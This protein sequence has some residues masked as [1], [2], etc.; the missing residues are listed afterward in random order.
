MSKVR[1]KSKN[2]ED[3]YPLSPL[4]EGLLFH[5]LYAPEAGVY[6]T[7]VTCTLENLDVSALEQA[8]QRVV[9]RHPILRTAFIWKNLER[10]LQV[11]GRQVR[12]PLEGQDWRGL[13]ATGQE[14]RFAAYLQADRR[15]GFQLSQAPLMR[16]ALFQVDEDTYKLVWSHHHVL[17]DGWS[18]HLLIK[19]VFLLYEG[20]RK[21]QNI[22]LP[23]TRPYRDYIAWL[24]Q[25]DMAA[26]EAFWRQELAGFTAPNSLGIDRVMGGL[27]GEEKSPGEHRIKLSAATT[28]ALQSLARTSQLTLNTLVQGALALL[29]SRYSGEDDIVFG[30][31]VSGRPPELPGADATAG[32]FINTLPVR[33]R[34]SPN[35]PLL[36][37]LRQLQEQQV[38]M[39]RY[40]YSPLVNVQ[41]WSDVPRDLPLFKCLY[42]FEN[43]PVDAPVAEHEL[44][45]EVRDY[46][47]VEKVTYP[48]TI[49]SGPSQE[50]TLKALYDRQSFD[51][52]TVDRVL[53]HFRALLEGIVANPECRLFDLTPLTEAER[54]QLLVEWNET[55]ADYPQGR[56]IHGLF[57]AQVERSPEAI[58]AVCEGR[59]LTYEEL[60]KRANQLAH[61]LRALGVGPEVLVA[62][63]LD[64]TL[65]MLI[66]I[67]GI[68][69]ASGAY[70]PMDPAYPAERL[71][72]ILEDTQAP[73]LLTQARLKGMLPEQKAKVVCLDADWETI[74]GESSENLTGGVSDDNL[75]YVIYTS[76]STGRPK[77]VAIE[78][79]ST[80][81]LLNWAKEVFGP[82]NLAS[83]LASTSICFDLSVYEMFVPLS[84]GGEVILAENA[85][86]LPRLPEANH[87]TLINTVPS[88]IAELVRMRSVPQ[89]VRTVNLAGEPLPTRLV[90]QIYQQETVERVFD[91]YGPSEDTTYST[92]ALRRSEG[93][94]TI[95]RPI[96]NTQM[97]L[98]DGHLQ[99]TPLGVAG[100]L[101]I[102]GEGLARGYLNRPELTAEKFIPHPFSEKPGA[103]LYKTG[104]LARYL[105]DGN[106]EFLGRIDHQVKIRGFRIE[107]GEI[108]TV[109][110]RHPGVR[111]LVV[112]AREDAPG[113]KRLV[114]YIVPEPENKPTGGELR[115]YLQQKLPEYLVPSAFV[116]LEALPL[117]PNG[118]VDRKR[119][120]AP[121]QFS[122]ASAGTFVAPR[123]P[124]EELLAGIWVDVLSIPQVG[125][126]DDFFELGGHSLLATRLISRIRDAFQ[127][128]LPLASI[129]D[130]STI[131]SL[132]ERIEA[133]KRGGQS[134]SAPPLQPIPREEDLPL[135]FAQHRLWFL[136]QL[137]PGSNAYNIHAAVRLSGHLDAE[138]LEQSVSEVVRR[139]EALRTTFANVAGRPVQVI[140]PATALTL[141]RVD[142]MAL[143]ESDRESELLQLASAEAQRPFDLAAGPLF[144]ATLVQMGAEEHAVLLTMHHIISDGWSIG[145]LIKEM[146]SLYEAFSQG[147]PS[148]LSAL[149]IQYADFASWQRQWMQGEVLEKQLAYWTKRLAGSPPILE[150]P[151]DRPR[152]AVKTSRGAV[153][154]IKLSGQLTE[155]L[156]ELSRREGV[157]LFMTLLAAFQTL[158]HRYSSQDDILVGSPIAGRTRSEVEGLIGFF[159]NTLVLRTSFSGDASFREVLRQVRQVTLDAYAHQ[160]LPFE[161][162]VEALQPERD[163]SHSPLF[164]VMFVLQNTPR[165]ALQLPGLSLGQLQV[166]GRVAKF[167]LTLAMTET[168]RGLV[169]ALEYNTDLFDAAAIS[170]MIEHFQT[171]LESVVAD[172][173]QRISAL[174]LMSEQETERLLLEWNET[175]VDYSVEKLLPSLFEAQVERT[176]EAVALV[177]EETQ[178]TYRELNERANQVA[179]YLQHLRVGPEV[180]V[181]ICLERS[182]EMVAGILGVLKAGGAYVPLDPA[183]PLERLAFMLEDSR[184]PVLLTAQRLIEG[185]GETIRNLRSAIRNPVVVCLDA[186]GE[187]LAQESR[188]NPAPK[189]SED[190]PAYVIYTSGSTGKPKGAVISHRAICNHMLWLVNRFSLGAADRVLQKTPFSFDASVWEFYAPLLVGGQLVM[191]RPGGHQDGAYLVRAIAEHQVTI[192]Q[193]VPSLLRMLLDEEGFA[194]CESLRC[195]FCGGEALPTELQERF[196]V[197]LAAELHNL[198]GPTEASIDVTSWACQ[199]AGDRPIALIGRPISNTQIYLLSAQLQ[200]VPIGV[201]G[202]LHIGGDN[203]ARGYLNRPGLTAERF[204]PNPF[205]QEP[206]AR[207]YKTGDLARYLS[208]GN[209]EFLGRIDHQVKVRGFRIEL[210]EIEAVLRR[211]PAVDESIVMVREDRPGDKRLVAYVVARQEPA[212]SVGELRSLVKEKLP[213][214]M[215]PA[216]F[217]FLEALPLTPNRKVDRK[218][219]PKPDYAR[220]VLEAA[221]VAPRTPTEEKLAEIW[222]QLLGVAQVGIYDNFFELGGHSLLATQLVSRV[223]EAFEMELP[224][225]S[226]FEVP[227][228]AEL[229][230]RISQGQAQEGDGSRIERLRRGEGSIE[231]LVAELSQLSDDEVQAL[232]AGEVRLTQGD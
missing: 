232:L 91:L 125:I 219:L 142:L 42:A 68:L 157:T 126:N 172:P 77:G 202:E 136:D 152:P 39:R 46:H 145:V 163:T 109:L 193:L 129:F 32:L 53:G 216:A 67:L 96:A 113:E 63:C 199:W 128:E 116:I 76:G 135:S 3:T 18:V 106:I 118:K 181:G 215:V 70:V 138:A 74:S 183:Y 148:P 87:I 174:P 127:I 229:A 141:P 228:I 24:Q 131:A 89:S 207:L 51:T 10:P 117:T 72:F 149:P 45:V 154:D 230:E 105:P 159:V 92:S 75:A 187:A 223:R 99:P 119:L 107:L 169:G 218:R 52:S 139:H 144:R 132:A 155:A 206:G 35:A 196:A 167:D 93:P 158:L 111:E 79:R 17:L 16:L 60:N 110:G 134:L 153:Q 61:H 220:P 12:V 227:V 83:V 186:L 66:G 205:S 160:D 81:T 124:G 48:L 62:V 166:E 65:E 56:C 208:D 31:V 13:S 71:A 122:R 191:A 84:W 26:A 90:K 120:P 27:S 137:A 200:P 178:L 175:K 164:Q 95:G 151:T 150:L 43:Y 41:G 114:A 222:S 182:V 198:Y 161:Q 1:T 201:P 177:F 197:T 170:R 221:F 36:P 54:H 171:L 156:K 28:A 121:E 4:Q 147:R 212:P 162:L 22:N 38:E 176:P 194:K 226:L 9:D 184:A 185:L 6:V 168:E 213:E 15:R 143:P 5:S 214:Y 7:Q 101:Y 97:Y 49:L 23:P 231:E 47:V 14:E 69:K 210:G 146:A 85:L 211:H 192:L 58:A 25:Q 33:V 195:V 130:A 73:V 55:A 64:R 104:D 225:I 204:I 112:L 40:E 102:S 100:E 2:I 86:Q 173:K 94:A 50:L 108:E 98:L 115:D 59:Q 188:E 11:V 78:H 8:W 189:V 133:E 21:G 82:D 19:E 57:E 44:S 80:V 217:V 140:S 29:L 180:L 224:L 203:L 165:Q 20:A 179:H 209:L 88:A 30:A 123:T 190:N 103:R 34:V 37:W